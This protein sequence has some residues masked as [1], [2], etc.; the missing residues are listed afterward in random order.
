M[1]FSG[2]RDGETTSCQIVTGA[3]FVDG[4]QG[5][6]CKGRKDAAY[7]SD[8]SFFANPAMPPPTATNEATAL[9]LRM[10]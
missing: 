8:F 10:C 7:S 3:P 5:Q 9:P 4:W 6:G 2:R 1:T